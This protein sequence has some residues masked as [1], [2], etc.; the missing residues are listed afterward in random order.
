MTNLTIFLIWYIIGMITTI[1]SRH[2]RQYYKEKHT[3][4]TMRDIILLI[5]VSIAGPI[6]PLLLF[7]NWVHDEKVLNKPLFKFKKPPYKGDE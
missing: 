6:V 4:I 3:E 5:L 2:I 7:I 1:Y